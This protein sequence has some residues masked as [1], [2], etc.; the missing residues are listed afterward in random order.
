MLRNIHSLLLAITTL[1]ST[2]TTPPPPCT[3]NPN[4][5]IPEITAEQLLA[6]APKIC[7][8]VTEECHPAAE[9]VRGINTAFAN[10]GLTKLG[11]KAAL[12]GLMALESVDFTFN[13]NSFPGRPGQGTKAMLSFPHIYHY[14]FSQPACTAEVLRISNGKFLNVTFS[15]MDTIPIMD[16]KAIRA[17]VLP[18]KYTYAAASW[19]LRNKCQASVRERLAEGGFEGFKEYIGGCIFAGNVTS[20]RLA[21]WCSAV[22]ALKPEGMRAPGECD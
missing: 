19:Y 14:A 17:L 10:H 3:F 18:E 21:K 13:V 2:I 11:Q 9:A 20:E 5:T 7:T 6:A 8:T 22:K 15:N 16:Q 12:L 4:T 1:S